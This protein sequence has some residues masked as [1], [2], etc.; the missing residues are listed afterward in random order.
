MKWKRVVR[1]A[2]GKLFEPYDYSSHIFLYPDYKLIYMAVPK[3]AN[4]SIKSALWPL[5][6]EEA[7][8]QTPN[9]ERPRG[10]YRQGGDILFKQ[11]LRLFKHQ[12]PKYRGHE[13]VAFVRN[14]WD[15]LVSCYK[16]K[17]AEGSVTEDGTRK[18]R[19]DRA[20]YR[21]AGFEKDMP[22]E[23]F[24]RLVSETPDANANRHFRSQ[25]T[26]LTDKH[27]RLLPTRIGRFERLSEDFNAIMESLGAGHITLPRLRYSD[28]ADYRAYYTEELRDIVAE[29]FRGDI[30]LFDYRF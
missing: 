19:E 17:I 28:A 30:E 4:S 2:Y 3:V 13:I 15:R 8:E 27:G 23:E 22:F 6:P 9:Q 20:M 7:R 5:F 26:Y 24:V 14:P 25:H 21:N 11:G 29:R 1:R 12:V 16:D 18:T 10:L